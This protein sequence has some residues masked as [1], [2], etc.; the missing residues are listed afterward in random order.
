[1][2]IRP[3]RRRMTTPSW[4]VRQMRSPKAGAQRYDPSEEELKTGLISSEGGVGAATVFAAQETPSG[5]INSLNTTY[6]LTHVPSA[7]TLNLFLDGAL[8]I[9]G[10][11]YTLAGATITFTV[12]PTTGQIMAASYLY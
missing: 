1:M 7:N 5:L 6:T 8:Q 3:S 2:N 12:A 9:N 11:D 4:G 10:V